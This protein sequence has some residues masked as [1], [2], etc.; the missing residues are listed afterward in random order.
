M[1]APRNWFVQT[2][3]LLLTHLLLESAKITL[4]SRFSMK[5]HK[6]NS[7]ISV[8]LSSVQ[9]NIECL[10]VIG[11]GVCREEIRPGEG[12]PGWDQGSW[13]FHGDDGEFFTGRRF[14]GSRHYGPTFGVNDV[15][16]C[17]VDYVADSL[18][19]TLNGQHLGMQP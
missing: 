13:G 8:L 10:S 1:A 6:G 7:V 4:K 11:L 14:N 16:G 5:E 3:P 19:F 15:I 2:T 9:A 17:C 18:F 12:M